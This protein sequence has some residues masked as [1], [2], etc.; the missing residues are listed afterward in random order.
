MSMFFDMTA[1][2]RWTEGRDQNFLDGGAHSTASMNAT[3]A[4]SSRSIDRA[5]ILCAAA[6]ACRTDR[7]RFRR[8]NATARPWP[9]LKEKLTKVF[10]S[11]TARG[12]VQDHGGHRHLLRADPDMAEAPKHPHNA[13]RK[14]FVERHGITPARTRPAFFAHA[15]G[16]PRAGGCGNR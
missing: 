10:L 4:I 11:K 5:A 2:G 16:D 14:I 6:P 15:V 7:R 13:A 9:A 1:I 3:A 8:P 12:L